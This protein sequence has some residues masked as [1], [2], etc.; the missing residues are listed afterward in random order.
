MRIKFRSFPGYPC[1]PYPEMTPCCTGSMVPLISE[2]KPIIAPRVYPPDAG[3]LVKWKRTA[4]RWS[5]CFGG[6]GVR[7]R[8]Y[9]DAAEF[10]A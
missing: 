8:G 1:A 3:V 9:F 6:F 7:K 4:E 2:Q 10:G 5:Y